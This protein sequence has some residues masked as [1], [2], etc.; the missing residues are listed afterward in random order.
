MATQTA[1]STVSQTGQQIVQAASTTVQR[2]PQ[3]GQQIV[4]GASTT[5]QRISQH[6]QKNVQPATPNVSS[7]GR[8]QHP[9]MKEIAQRRS[10]TEFTSKNVQTAVLNAFV[11]FVTFATSKYVHDVVDPVIKQTQL[12]AVGVSTFRI[13]LVVRLLLLS[14]LCLCFRPLLPYIKKTDAVEDIPLTPSQRALLGLPR[15]RSN[16]PGSEQVGNYI[17]PPRY[18]K[19]S[20]STFANAAQSGGSGRSIS[21]NYSASPLSTSRFAVGFSP[22]PQ[23]ASAT[24]GRRLSGSP[25]SPSSPL[26]NKTLVNSASMNSIAQNQDFTE[27][28]RSLLDGNMSTTSFQSSLRRSHSMRERGGRP[29]EP[30]TPSPS[31]KDRSKVKVQPG[32]NYKWLYEKGLTVGKNG[33]IE[34]DR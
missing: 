3:Q 25:F 32:L 23:Q 5:V 21:A 12:D 15:S 28:T 16:T 9:R 30:G 1:L 29:Q 27:S 6:G 19:S 33:S 31:A 34:Y 7:P 2:I 18:H 11:L 17:T 8:F 10:A 14:N 13:L 26:Y 4:Q 20:P 22:T 24:P